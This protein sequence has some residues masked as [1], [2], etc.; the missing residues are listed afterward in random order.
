VVDEDL[1]FGVDWLPDVE[2]FIEDVRG[3]AVV[4][5]LLLITLVGSSKVEAGVDTDD[6]VLTFGGG[7]VSTA[8][9]AVVTA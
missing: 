4:A 6:I 5:G 2:C 8:D 7:F 3:I 1:L 9:V